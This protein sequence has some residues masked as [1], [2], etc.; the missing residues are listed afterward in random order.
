[1]SEDKYKIRET[2]QNLFGRFFCAIGE[3]TI[4]LFLLP[5]YKFLICVV[6]YAS[7]WNRI[8]HVFLCGT[9]PL[10]L[11]LSL[12]NNCNIYQVCRF[13]STTS[14]NIGRL[15]RQTFHLHRD[16]NRLPSFGLFLGLLPMSKVT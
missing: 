13:M 5:N 10:S 16:Q 6:Q 1:M 7:F 8:Y 15:N 12:N 14:R 11:S 9:L 3:M 2:F 4:K